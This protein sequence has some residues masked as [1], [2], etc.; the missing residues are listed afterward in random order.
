MNRAKYTIDDIK[1]NLARKITMQN[2][3]ILLQNKYNKTLFNSIASEDYKYLSNIGKKT[4]KNIVNL[5][6]GFCLKFNAKMLLFWGKKDRATKPWI[7]KKI[8]RINKCELIVSKY[9]HFAY[10]KDNIKFCNC[11]IN[12]LK[13]KKIP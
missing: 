11:A 8:K 13:N 7:A 2:N 1:E 12:F 10:L 4:F 3:K 5:N 6:L 9:D